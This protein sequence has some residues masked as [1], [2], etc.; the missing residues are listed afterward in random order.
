MYANTKIIWQF[1]IITRDPTMYQPTVMIIMSLL[2][3]LLQKQ[4]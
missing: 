1:H 3:K 2:N 4:D